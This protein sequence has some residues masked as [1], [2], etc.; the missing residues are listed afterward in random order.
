LLLQVAERGYHIGRQVDE[1]AAQL[2]QQAT[3][4]AAVAAE[5]AGLTARLQE[6]QQQQA[7]LLQRVSDA[8][9]SGAQ[10]GVRWR[11]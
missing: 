7:A 5:R 8:F 2:Q 11:C 10:V 6:A 9:V 4:L 1:Q 3:Q